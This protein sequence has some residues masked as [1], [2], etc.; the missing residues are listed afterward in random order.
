MELESSRQELQ[1]NVS[2]VQNKLEQ[3]RHMVTNSVQQKLQLKDAHLG[4]LKENTI[5]K[6]LA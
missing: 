2:Q 3:K 5:W 6:Q 1:D 4:V